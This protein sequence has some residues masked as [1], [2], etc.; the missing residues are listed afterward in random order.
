MNATKQLECK[1]ILLTAV[2]LDVIKN[3]TDA[4]QKYNMGKH[5][6]TLVS[7]CLHTWALPVALQVSALKGSTLTYLSFDPVA[8]NCP[9]GLHATQ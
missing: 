7:Y 5:K 9:Q 1:K 6:H 3:S 8:N 4:Y 2:F